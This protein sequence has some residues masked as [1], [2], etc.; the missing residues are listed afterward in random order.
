MTQAQGKIKILRF[1]RTRFYVDSIPR[2]CKFPPHPLETLR[3]KWNCRKIH[4]ICFCSNLPQEGVRVCV[5]LYVCVRTQG[6][7][8]W[9]W[10]VGGLCVC[11][12]T[13]TLVRGLGGGGHNSA[14]S[15]PAVFVWQPSLPVHEQWGLLSKATHS[16]PW[17]L[18][19]LPAQ[20]HPSK[21][22]HPFSSTSLLSPFLLDQYT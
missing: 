6:N 18:G 7:W 9:G 11:V 19:A 2:G 1:C 12:H 3:T 5:C 14:H 4:R 21:D 16:V 8:Y 10:G 13:R 15:S 20:G 22:S 17:L